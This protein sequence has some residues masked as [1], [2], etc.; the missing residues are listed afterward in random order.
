MSP[1]AARFCFCNV[2]P[3]GGSRLNRESSSVEI[4]LDVTDRAPERLIAERLSPC[5]EARPG[6]YPDDGLYRVPHDP[7][8]SGPNVADES[9]H[10]CSLCLS[11]LLAKLRRAF[12]CGD[13]RDF[14]LSALQEAFLPESQRTLQ[15]G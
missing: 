13:V 10:E 1:G 8:A 3:G 5:T 11:K 4:E 14:P 15:S 9:R 2:Y 12:A 7:E 6:I